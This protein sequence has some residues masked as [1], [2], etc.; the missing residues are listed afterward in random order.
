MCVCAKLGQTIEC[1]V[2]DGY[3]AFTTLTLSS[4]QLESNLRNSYV[5]RINTDCETEC[6]SIYQFPTN[7]MPRIANSVSYPDGLYMEFRSICSWLICD[8]ENITSLRVI[9]IIVIANCIIV[10]VSLAEHVYTCME[11]RNNSRP[12]A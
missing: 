2:Y 9:N 7:I 10:H 3:V 11:N 1:N 4:S 5:L 8:A 6:M 12:V